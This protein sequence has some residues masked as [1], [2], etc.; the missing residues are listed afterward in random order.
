MHV[1]DL[2]HRDETQIKEEQEDVEHEQPL[3]EMEVGED[4][5]A[6]AAAN[7]FHGPV[8]QRQTLPT[9]RH[10]RPTP[11]ERLGGPPGHWV[12]KQQVWDVFF[13]KTGRFP[14]WFVTIVILGTLS[15]FL[16][17]SY[18]IKIIIKKNR[19]KAASQ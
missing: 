1:H 19:E 14:K 6:E 11:A 13:C 18:P 10:A 2:W 12:R 4:S 8:P 3:E 16:L 17:P 5:R 15:Y 7:V 9:G